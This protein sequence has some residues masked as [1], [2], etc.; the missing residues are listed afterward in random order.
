MASR[1]IGIG[2]DAQSKLISA[3]SAF[4]NA[5]TQAKETIAKVA[6]Y[7]NSTALE[8]AVKNQAADL[9][10]IEDKMKALLAE[11]QALAQMAT[12]LLNN[13][14]VSAG[15]SEGVSNSVQYQAQTDEVSGTPGWPGWA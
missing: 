14:H 10:L 4:Y 7:N 13:I 1:V 9:S 2:Y 5:R 12:A 8:A 11:A 15:L 3:A 6:Q